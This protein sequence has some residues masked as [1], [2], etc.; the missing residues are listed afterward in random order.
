MLESRSAIYKMINSDI[1][2]DRTIRKWPAPYSTDKTF[3]HD[4][5]FSGVVRRVCAAQPLLP[6]IS[7]VIVLGDV[8]VG[9]T[10]LVNRFCH[11][12][13]DTNYKATIGVDFEVEKFDVLGV[14]F[15]LQ[16]WDTAGQERFK[17]IA[18]SYYRGANV[19]MIVFDLG[20]LMSLHHCQQW[21]SDANS[22]NNGPYHIFLVGTKRDLLS[23]QV[24][25][26]VEKKA[27]EISRRM[28]AELWAVSAR[29]GDGVPELFAR[30][31]AL[32][33]NASV[34]REVQSARVEPIVFGSELIK[35]NRETKKVR[36]KDRRIP[37]CSNCQNQL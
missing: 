35:L 36:M 33:F 26:I 24:Y 30:V 16:I 23:N 2:S 5:D 11:K 18:A 3:Y 4:R 15:N 37:K 21:L 34:L 32:A 1:S 20:S 12:S 25:D 6:R 14:P 19:V 22:C 31:A 28:R 29:T 7:K 10:S 17:C 13:F 8:A 27:V 9:K